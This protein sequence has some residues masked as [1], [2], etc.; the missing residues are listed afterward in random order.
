MR[1]WRLFMLLRDLWTGI[2]FVAIVGILAHILGIVF[3]KD[4]LC[5]ESFPFKA[6]SWEK[7]GTFYNRFHISKWMSKL[8]DMSR[9]VPYMFRKKL[10]GDMTA[11]HIMQYIKET[12]LAEL[13]HFLLILSSPILAL[14]VGGRR[15]VIFMLIYSF[16]NIPFIMIQRYNRPKLVRLY[17][18]QTEKEILREDEIQS[19]S[20]D[21]VV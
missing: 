16:C 15:G 14:I 18:R 20:D 7:N 4:C 2:K 19:E 8:P 13:V 5:H 3:P 9:I 12:C 11:E 1:D 21:T 17:R 6:F 10:D